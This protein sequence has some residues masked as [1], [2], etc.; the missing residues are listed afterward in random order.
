MPNK[1]EAGKEDTMEKSMLNRRCSGYRCGIPLIAI[2]AQ[3]ARTMTEQ[4]VIKKIDVQEESSHTIGRAPEADR[5]FR[6]ERFDVV[7]RERQAGCSI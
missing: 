1:R 7:C 5:G 6:V 3:R 2:A 4:S